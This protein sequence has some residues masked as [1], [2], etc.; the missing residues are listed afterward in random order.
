M[1]SGPAT[2]T[3]F[4]RGFLL[5]LVTAWWRNDCFSPTA[6]QRSAALAKAG[7][8][9]VIV[10]SRTCNR[11]GVQRS[12]PAPCSKEQGAKSGMGEEGR[13][14]RATSR[15]HARFPVCPPAIHPRESPVSA[16]SAAIIRRAQ[17]LSRFAE[18]TLPHIVAPRNTK[19]LG[20]CAEA[21][22]DETSLWKTEEN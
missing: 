16:G 19:K 5:C 7:C 2:Q 8:R 18:P 15:A 13:N 22:E 3:A 10:R 17:E 6:L 21:V 12:C 9:F 11:C 14:A 4:V 1:R 20:G